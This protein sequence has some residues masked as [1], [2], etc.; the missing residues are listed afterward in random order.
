MNQDSDN[1]ATKREVAIASEHTSALLETIRAAVVGNDLV[2]DGP[3]G[4][5][6]MVYADHTAS[7][8]SLHFIEDFIRNE[9]MPV[10]ANTHSE[11]SGTGLLTNHLRED[12]R[13]IIRNSLGGGSDD[14]VIF[15]GSGATAAIDKLIHVMNLRLPAELVDKYQLLDHIPEASRPVVFVG[16]YEHH[17]NEISWRETIADVVAIREDEHGGIDLAHLDAEL[18]RYARR[19]L[20][21]G[22]FSA[23]SNVT[24]VISDCDAI[25]ELLHLRGALSFWDYA[26]AGPH[27]PIE[28]NSFT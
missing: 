10:Y 20:K 7:G 5:R 26:A 28:M 18:S 14:L 4:P 16:P 19:P 12:A 9:V 22:S 27:L 23:A 17:S 21:I 3:F 1:E 15:V 13:Q 8:Q 11:S 25:A 2:L 24:G 6:R